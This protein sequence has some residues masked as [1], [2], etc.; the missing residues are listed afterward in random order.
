MNTS[1]TIA[2]LNEEI[3][4]TKENYISLT[5]MLRSK[6]GNFFI[7]DWLRHRNTV[8]YPGIWERVHNQDFNYGE[9]STIRRRGNYNG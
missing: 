4:I 7:T 6:D 5:D 2:V 9:F 8:E 3:I 1:K